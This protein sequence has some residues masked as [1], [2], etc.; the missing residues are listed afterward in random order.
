[1]STEDEEI[2]EIG[3]KCGLEVP[4][5]RPAQLA[6]DD[7]PTL[8][9]IQHA[10]RYLELTGD[11]YD[12]ICLLQPTN[13]CRGSDIID[14]CIEIFEKEGADTVMTILPVPAK[15]N[16]LWVY[17]E[18]EHGILQLSTGEENPITRRQ[19]LPPAFHREGSVYMCR[20]NIIMNQ[21]NIYRKRIIGYLPDPELSINIDDP[22]EWK[23]AEYLLSMKK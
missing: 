6:Q 1:L 10:L 14:T 11:K 16:P 23:R 22:E 9:V 4:F 2:A 15:F 13:P 17:F 8:P 19:D 3:K 7:T 20:C 18:K 21:G 12:A 5:M